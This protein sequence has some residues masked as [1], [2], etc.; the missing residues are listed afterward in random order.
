MS[1]IHRLP[2]VIVTEHQLPDELV[3]ELN[4]YLD[5][6][7]EDENKKSLSHTL[8]GQIHHGE[9][10]LMDHKEPALENYYKYIT[11]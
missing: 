11:E 7:K 6:Y 10:L 5:K 9:Q 3:K 8:V 1:I 2:A 4:D